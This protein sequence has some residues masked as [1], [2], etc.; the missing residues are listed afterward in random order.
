MELLKALILITIAFVTLVLFVKAIVGEKKEN[1][2][3][4]TTLS[5][6]NGVLFIL[7]GVLA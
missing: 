2:K 4:F 6:L 3:L 7:M 5:L 1:I